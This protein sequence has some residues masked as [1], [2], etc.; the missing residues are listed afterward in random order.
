L[1]FVVTKEKVVIDTYHNIHGSQLYDEEPA[2]ERN[3]SFNARQCI[4]L[5]S[6]TEML[7]EGM[8]ALL[9]TETFFVGV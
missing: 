9:K 1:G 8:M 7:A 5:N 3:N 2:V 4:L 6:V